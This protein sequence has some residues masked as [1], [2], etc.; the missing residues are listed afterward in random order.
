MCRVGQH[1][2]S[3][4]GQ[5]VDPDLS[6][7]CQELKTSSSFATGGFVQAAAVY[8]STQNQDNHLVD[9]RVRGFDGW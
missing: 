6:V 7:R 3:P 8:I 1:T 4:G 2:C 5:A 9:T